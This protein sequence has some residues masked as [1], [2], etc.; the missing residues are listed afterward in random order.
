MR[1]PR[2]ESHKGFGMCKPD[3]SKRAAGLAALAAETGCTVAEILGIPT[4][5][6]LAAHLPTER[7][8]DVRAPFDNDNAE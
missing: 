4:P 7:D 1:I 3:H 2:Y 6:I 5:A 8:E